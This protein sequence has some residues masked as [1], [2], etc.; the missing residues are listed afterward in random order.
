[1]V[2]AESITFVEEDMVA[3]RPECEKTATMV[4]KNQT[5]EILDSS[6]DK[7]AQLAI[8]IEKGDIRHKQV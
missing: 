7:E 1:M 5:G 3:R 6:M 2:Q 4:G 8:S